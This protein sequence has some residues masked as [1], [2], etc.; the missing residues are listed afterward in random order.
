VNVERRPEFRAAILTPEPGDDPADLEDRI[1]DEVVASRRAGDE[2][3]LAQ[4]VLDLTG[5]ADMGTWL[6]AVGPQVPDCNLR[7]AVGEKA[8]LVARTLG[9]TAVFEI[10]ADVDSALRMGV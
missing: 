6:K 9:L 2:T 10:Y 5:V 4:V 1:H 3:A 7:M 8:C